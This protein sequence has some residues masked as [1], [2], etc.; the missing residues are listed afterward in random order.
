MQRAA[1]PFS[2]GFGKAAVAAVKA[3]RANKNY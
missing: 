2:L 3:N 1:T